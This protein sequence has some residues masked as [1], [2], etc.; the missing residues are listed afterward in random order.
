SKIW[1]YKGLDRTLSTVSI[2][3]G[4]LYIADV[5]GRLH[6][7]NV[8]TGEVQWIYE[9]DSRTIASALVA[10]GKIFLPTEKHLHILA[11][12]N[13]MK[14]LSRISLGVPSWITP[15]AA[16]GTLYIAS[17]NYLWAVK[18]KDAEK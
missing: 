2:S 5:A 11:A 13:Q 9:S 8:D 12:G 16:N 4:L 7:L 15:V 14:L 17:R 18:H 6:C 1:T 3:D 10:D